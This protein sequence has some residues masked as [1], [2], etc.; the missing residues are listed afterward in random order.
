MAN[1]LKRRFNFRFPHHLAHTFSNDDKF[2]FGCPGPLDSQTKTKPKSAVVRVVRGS[3][4]NNPSL[5]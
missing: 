5:G 1:T 2:R 4:A 3:A